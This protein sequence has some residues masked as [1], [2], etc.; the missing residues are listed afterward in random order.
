[1]EYVVLN[2]YRCILF[3][4]EFRVIFGVG[5]CM[6]ELGSFF[7][8]PLKHIGLASISLSVL[9]IRVIV[10]SASVGCA[11]SESNVR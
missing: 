8:S 11:Y 3:V 2:F 9:V 6:K 1:M 7:E 10:I 5:V 4:W